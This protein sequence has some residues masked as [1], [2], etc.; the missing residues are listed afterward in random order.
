M[1]RKYPLE[2]SLEP[3]IVPQRTRWLMLNLRNIGD[4]DLKSMAVTLNSLDDRS[5]QVHSDGK[6]VLVLRPDEEKA[7][8]IQVSVER[9][10]QVYI[11]IDGWLEDNEFHWESPPIRITTGREVAEIES[12][13]AQTTPYPTLGTPVTSKVRVR[14]MVATENLVI[15]FWVE[16]P[17]GELL[18]PDK[19]G[20]GQQPAN[21]VVERDMEITPEEQGIYIIH[22]YLYD[23]ARRIDHATEHLSITR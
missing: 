5:I 7:I 23:G 11:N 16:T 8:P 6:F 21:T 22:A 19:T 12:L 14:S 20:L 10:G 2:Y 17:S 15:A 13:L 3:T 1:P 18:S 9:R 4:R